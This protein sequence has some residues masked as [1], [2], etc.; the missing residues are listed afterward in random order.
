MNWKHDFYKSGYEGYEHLEKFPTIQDL[1]N[2][3]RLLLQKTEKQAQFIE[4]RFFNK[5]IR[6]IEY[7]SGN[8]RLLIALSL[9]KLLGYGMGVEISRSRVAFAQKWISD[10]DLNHLEHFP[11]D[12]LEFN[13]FQKGSFDLAVCLT[14]AFAYFGP[15]HETAPASLL[16]KMRAALTSKGTLLLELY[17][18]PKKRRQLL[19]LNNNKLRVWRP[20]PEEDRFVYYL[21]DFEYSPEQRVLKHGKIFIG[22]DGSIDAGRVEMLAY[23]TLAQ[24]SNLLWQ[25]GFEVVSAAEDFEGTEYR[26]G[27]SEA[28]IVLARCL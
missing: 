28:L 27:E 9:R 20:L 13:A 23:Y 4:R 5:K 21:D 1:E 17:Q 6:V 14:G 7:C 16:A 24:L 19:A 8:G 15:I 25:N 10:L 2:Y 12:A 18:M 26:E 3:R 22:R 11:V